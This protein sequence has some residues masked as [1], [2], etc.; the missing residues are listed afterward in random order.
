M[1]LNFDLGPAVSCLCTCI[2][3]RTHSLHSSLPRLSPLS[4]LLMVLQGGLVCL[5]LE[6][7]LL[8]YP[9]FPETAFPTVPLWALFLFFFFFL[10]GG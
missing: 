9:H 1:Q 8:S 2:F 10:T 7:G 5:A 4:P 6:L 3:T